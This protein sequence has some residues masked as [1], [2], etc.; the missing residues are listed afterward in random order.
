MTAEKPFI[1]STE[2]NDRL[3]E[4]FV[5]AYFQDK[6]GKIF[7]TPYGC[8]YWCYGCEFITG[9]GWDGKGWLGYEFDEQTERPIPMD[10]SEAIAKA[11]EGEPLPPKYILMSP[12][13]AAKAYDAGCDKWG[14]GWTDSRDFDL[15][16][17]DALIQWVGLGEIRYG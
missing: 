5:K 11:E 4:K 6:G 9:K 17:V 2:E 12:E 10:H 14:L 8:G 7:N 3:R 13:F 16:D 15:G 1:V